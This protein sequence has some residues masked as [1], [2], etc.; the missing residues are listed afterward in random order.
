[1]AASISLSTWLYG[2]AGNDWIKAG[3]GNDIVLGG[4]GDDL[5]LGKGGLD[6]LI[7]GGGLDRIIGNAED[8]ILIASS[9]VHDANDQALSD[10]MEEWTSGSE[11]DVRVTNLRDIGVGEDGDIF[12]NGTTIFED[13]AR[14]ILTGSSG[15]DWFLWEDGE[16]KI[17]DLDDEEFDDVRVFI[18]SEI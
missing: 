3:G 7:G 12:L 8:D 10:I 2:D 5:L 16:D 6:L 11:Y 17:T 15:M 4:E 14:D 13:L 9:T 1:V 18:L